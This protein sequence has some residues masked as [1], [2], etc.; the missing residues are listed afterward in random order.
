MSF[1]ST[2]MFYAAVEPDFGQHNPKTPK[3]GPGNE[4]L[5]SGDLDAAEVKKMQQAEIRNLFNKVDRSK[6]Y[7]HLLLF[8][9]IHSFFLSFF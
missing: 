8:F 2:A 7:G 1:I 6:R 3:S 4:V 9:F 5:D